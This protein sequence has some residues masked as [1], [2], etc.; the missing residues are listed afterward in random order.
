MS[1]DF[2]PVFE[3]LRALYVVHAD[4]CVVLH[5][6]M[7][8]YYI[9]THE[10]RASD[11]YRTDFGGVEIKKAYVSVHLMPVYIH[12]GLLDS[13]SPDLRKRMQG[14]LCFNFKEHNKRLF[15]E[16]DNLIRAGASQ[17]EADSRL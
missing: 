17:F 12:P 6:D 11:G 3:A 1:A 2:V 7:S 16:L 8:R 5:D 15:E 4:K 14:K 9:G 10:V 13:V